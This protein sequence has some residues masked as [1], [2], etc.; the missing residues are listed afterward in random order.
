[1]GWKPILELIHAK[2]VPKIKE[3]VGQS[4]NVPMHFL[5]LSALKHGPQFFINVKVF[6]TKYN[7]SKA[8]DI[9]LDWDF[10]GITLKVS[11]AV[12][13]KIMLY[14]ATKPD[15]HYKYLKKL[16]DAQFSEGTKFKELTFCFRMNLEYWLKLG[17]YG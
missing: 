7:F 15:F 16:K 8:E 2:D 6:V 14:F 3:D 10:N 9:S 12:S 1:M 11:C 5:T 17:T 13:Y 4:A